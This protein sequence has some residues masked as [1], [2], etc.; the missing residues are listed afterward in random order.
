MKEMRVA[1]FWFSAA[2]RR[3]D[4]EKVALRPKIPG[5]SMETASSEGPKS[6]PFTTLAAN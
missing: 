2:G 4:Q 1:E 3:N 5:F 6:P